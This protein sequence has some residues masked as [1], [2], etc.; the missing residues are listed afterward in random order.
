MGPCVVENREICFEIASHFKQLEEELGINII[1]KAS[2][3][4]ANRT[5]LNS[6]VGIEEN[7]ALEILND[8]KATFGFN[9]CTDVHE[10]CDVNKVQEIADIIQIPAFLCRQTDLLV[11]AGKSGKIINIK[12]GQ[13]MSAQAMSFA[14][15]KVQSAGNNNVW[16]TE[17]G[18]S[19]GYNDLIVDI[20]NIP[21]MQSLGVPVICD[22]THANQRPNSPDGS[23]NGTPQYIEL[24][25]NACTA[26]GAD[27]LFIETHPNPKL[28]LSDASTML[29]L[30]KLKELLK[31][32]ITI[33]SITIN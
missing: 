19:F 2:F 14:V 21:I 23:T 26:A 27:G 31:K 16:L 1:Y 3:K 10:S 12:K 5:S 22:I 4:K 7:N 11:A 8:I 18:N 30:N 13:F 28:A 33:R 6:F 25:A 17:R 15:E 24:L 9:I 32:V 29:P 20:R